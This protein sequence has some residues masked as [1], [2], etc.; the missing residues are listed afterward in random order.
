M[1]RAAAL[2]YYASFSVPAILAVAISVAEFFYTPEQVR[3]ELS[4]QVSRAVGREGAEKAEPMLSAAGRTKP[5]TI[6][7]LLSIA[8]VL[9]SA[10][11]VMV[12]L[13][14]AL[15]KAWAVKPDPAASNLKRFLL[16][17]LFS[18]VMVLVIAP[19]LLVALVSDTLLA[20]FSERIAAWLPGGIS[21]ELL[22]W[23]HGGVALVVIS[24]LLSAMFKFLPDA[25]I[26]W[27]D[28]WPGAVLT[29][30]L[31]AVGNW[32][33]ALYLRHSNLASAYGAAGSLAIL[34]VWVYYA[35]MIVLFGAEFTRAWA[36]RGGR[37]VRPAPGFL[38]VER[39][40]G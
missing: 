7:S 23:A 25:V 2:S 39:E 27:R 8:M 26:P 32:A 12:E 18:V 3:S 19:L 6:A 4:K 22:G 1:E 11:G 35:A 20:T 31:L 37:P 33:V 5:A 36:T 17:R 15:N 28:A 24:L 40:Q 38:A 13:Q 29:A 10:T 14:A 16:K 30:L 9:A 34:L 21:A